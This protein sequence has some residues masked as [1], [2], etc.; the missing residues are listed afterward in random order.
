MRRRNGVV[1]SGTVG[2]DSWFAI[3]NQQSGALTCKLMRWQPIQSGLVTDLEEGH[4]FGEVRT[5]CRLIA[6]S[7]VRVRGDR[8]APS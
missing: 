3:W 6:L 5:A 7:Q 1:R 8:A 2:P 4:Y